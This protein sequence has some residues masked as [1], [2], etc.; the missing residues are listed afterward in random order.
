MVKERKITWLAKPEEHD[1][2]AAASYLSLFYD[3]PKVEALAKKLKQAPVVAT[4]S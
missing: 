3:K 1:Y 2:P 4:R